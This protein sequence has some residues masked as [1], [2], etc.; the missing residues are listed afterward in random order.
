M[1]KVEMIKAA[2]N[3]VQF[4]KGEVAQCV[5]VYKVKDMLGDILDLLEF[6]TSGQ[7][8]QAGYNQVPGLPVAEDAGKTKVQ[9]FRDS[10]APHAGNAINAG[11]G[12]VQLIPTGIPIKGGD[13]LGD[14]SG[15]GMQ[16]A[17][18]FDAQGNQVDANGNLLAPRRGVMPSV[19]AGG[20]LPGAVPPPSASP[21]LPD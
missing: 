19:E 20:T 10:S 16:R 13:A 7:V 18:F 15:P 1:N 3:R 8:T 12:D 4:L 21:L 6:L 9:L 17:E 2:A 5:N 14:V 11:A